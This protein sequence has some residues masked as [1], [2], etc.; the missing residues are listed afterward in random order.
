MREAVG[1]GNNFP[2]SAMGASEQRLTGRFLP[3]IQ[4]L[5]LTQNGFDSPHR[6]SELPLSIDFPYVPALST[7]GYEHGGYINLQTLPDETEGVRIIAAQTEPT[8]QAEIIELRPGSYHRQ[9]QDEPQLDSSAPAKNTEE[10]PYDARDELIERYPFMSFQINHAAMNGSGVLVPSEESRLRAM[11]R[12]LQDGWPEAPD[13]STPQLLTLHKRINNLE[14]IPIEIAGHKI[15][16]SSLLEI[17]SVI[18]QAYDRLTK[19]NHPI[20]QLLAQAEAE[21]PTLPK[22]VREDFRSHLTVAVAHDDIRKTYLAAVREK[23]KTL[24]AT[25]LPAVYTEALDPLQ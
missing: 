11:L 4:L 15:K 20:V 13:L 18:D 12:A 9:T 5:N 21:F 24:R 16:R 19:A 17:Q 8:Q 14:K 10:A 3:D 6:P 1:Q 7:N 25:R 22:S 23:V 2:P